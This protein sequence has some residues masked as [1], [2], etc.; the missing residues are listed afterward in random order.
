MSNPSFQPSRSVQEVVE[1]LATALQPEKIILFNRKLNL[2]GEVS[3]FKL[4]L[5]LDTQ[6]K[7]DAEL[8][9]YL[10]VDSP[11]PFDVLVYTPEEWHMLIDQKNSFACQVHQTGVVLY[12][13]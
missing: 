13:R 3:S 11:I 1:T 7:L 6:D 5:I 12:E 10:I 9:A 8:E 2:Q 4:C